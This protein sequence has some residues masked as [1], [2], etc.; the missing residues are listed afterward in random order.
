MNERTSNLMMANSAASCGGTGGM[1]WR[2]FAR[3]RSPV[4]L[5]VLFL[6]LNIL[7]ANAQASR[8]Y[9]IKAVFL[10]NFAQFTE[11]PKS[12]FS[13]ETSPMIIGIVGSDPFGPALTE[14]VHGESVQGHPVV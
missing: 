12:A 7:P 10:Y 3:S 13:G 2:F 6:A 8:E 9:Q 14:T 11:W 5:A 4:L 1:D